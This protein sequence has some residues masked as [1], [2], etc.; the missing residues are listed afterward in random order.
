MSDRGRKLILQ[1]IIAISLPLLTACSNEA[2]TGTVTEQTET[3]Q[4]VKGGSQTVGEKESQIIEQP[5][6]Q[7]EELPAEETPEEEQL[8]ERTETDVDLT[9]SQR[10]LLK[11]P[12]Y[13]SWQSET[14]DVSAKPISISLLSED[15]N[16]ITD[17]ANWFVENNLYLNSV[18]D[19]HEYGT[20]VRTAGNEMFDYNK[21]RD[22]H[23]ICLYDDAYIY[24]VGS[25]EAYLDSENASDLD[26][27]LTVYDKEFE[28]VLYQLDF[29]DFCI[30]SEAARS[31]NIYTEVDIVWV[32]ARD[33][34]L[35][36]ALTY[37]GYAKPNTSF[38]AAVSLNTMDIIWK[39]ES[40]VCN[41]YNFVLTEDVLICGYGFTAE[42]DYLY[43][44]DLDTGKVLDKTELK[45]KPDYIVLKDDQLYVRCYNT[46][47]VF[48]INK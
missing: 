48:Q 1:L 16:N 33:H 38:V 28:E 4:E 15:S 47:Y 39:S 43:Q 40:L 17:T 8:E 19:Y 3:E 36:V 14:T 29:S 37:N 22:E 11:S 30:E 45:S 35:Y 24:T 27:L 18:S 6:E 21:W 46:D 42:P 20:M 26:C 25:M 2:D 12:G 10:I 13:D 34:I 5:N 23:R 41:S 44:L 31:E 7:N 32:Q 9:G